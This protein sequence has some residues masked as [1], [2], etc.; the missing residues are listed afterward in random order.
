MRTPPTAG[1]MMRAPL[2]VALLRATAFTTCSRPTISTTNDWRT[3]M[4]TALMQPRI[5]ART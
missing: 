2:K 4:S 5:A 1:P 3:G